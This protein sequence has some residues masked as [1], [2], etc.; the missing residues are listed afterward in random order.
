MGISLPIPGLSAGFDRNPK[1]MYS[2][3]AQT[4]TSVVPLRTLVLW[5]EVKILTGDLHSNNPQLVHFDGKEL[6]AM[7]PVDCLGLWGQLFIYC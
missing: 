2:P 5:L 6:S 7:A 3:L 4:A 1:D